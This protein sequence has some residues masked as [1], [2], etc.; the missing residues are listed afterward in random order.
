MLVILR[1]GDIVNYHT[2]CERCGEEEGVV[3]G[4]NHLEHVEIRPYNPDLF[5]F[6]ICPW[7]CWVIDRDVEV[8]SVEEGNEHV[9]P[10]VLHIFFM[11]ENVSRSRI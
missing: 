8:K 10:P 7:C 2:P 11:T 5:L 4:I 1:A 3:M 6:E 9:F